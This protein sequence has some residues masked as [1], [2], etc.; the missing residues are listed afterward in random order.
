MKTKTKVMIAAVIIAVVSLT[1]LCSTWDFESAV[2]RCI[3][4]LTFFVG[5]VTAGCIACTYEG[6]QNDDF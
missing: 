3:F 4:S 5:L 1:V 6:G 2:V